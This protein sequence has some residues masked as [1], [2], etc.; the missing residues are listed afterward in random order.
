[1]GEALRLFN[2]YL[3]RLYPEESNVI[4]LL[5][6]DS[7]CE[8]NGSLFRLFQNI[9]TLDRK[10]NIFVVEYKRW[11][12]D[13]RPNIP[14]KFIWRP[15]HTVEDVN[16]LNDTYKNLSLEEILRKIGYSDKYKVYSLVI[17]KS[18][19]DRSSTHQYH[20]WALIEYHTINHFL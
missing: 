5:D 8:P 20:W 13:D 19:D 1:M 10:N 18:W 2:F 14:T 3:Y 15:I 17:K 12:S 9:W 7:F 11:I 16:K 6:G 4:N